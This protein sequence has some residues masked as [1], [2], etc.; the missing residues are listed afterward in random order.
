MNKNI[1]I[2][3]FPYDY[4]FVISISAFMC[5]LEVPRKKWE[6]PDRK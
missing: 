5:K 2:N 6:H 1:D 4:G 3:I